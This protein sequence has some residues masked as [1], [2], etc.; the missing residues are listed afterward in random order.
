MAVA[1][2]AVLDFEDGIPQGLRNLEKRRWT[3]RI[4]QS[5]KPNVINV[6]SVYINLYFGFV[7]GGSKAN[8]HFVCENRATKV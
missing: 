7:T 3:V 1:P 5:K 2:T 8:E 4:W 6:W